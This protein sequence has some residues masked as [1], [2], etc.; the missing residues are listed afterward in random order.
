[1]PVAEFDAHKEWSCSTSGRSEDLSSRRFDRLKDKSVMLAALDFEVRA[2]V[3]PT[4]FV[5]VH[6]ACLSHRDSRR[7]SVPREERWSPG[8]HDVPLLGED[9][10]EWRQESRVEHDLDRCGRADQLV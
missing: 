6:I 8:G 9:P 7:R 2:L 5:D 1:M 10:P 3:C 4:R